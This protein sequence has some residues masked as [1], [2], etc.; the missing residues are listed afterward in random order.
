MHTQIRKI[1]NSSGAIIPS[2]Y[3]KKLD[4]KEGDSILIIEEEG[5]LVISKDTTRPKYSLDELL[6]KCDPDAPFIDHEW[7]SMP[8]AGKEVL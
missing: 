7:D 4:L 3:L 6:A 1:G 2:S 5:K 8:P